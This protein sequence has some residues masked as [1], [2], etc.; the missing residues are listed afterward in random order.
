[1]PDPL[2]FDRSLFPDKRSAFRTVPHDRIVGDLMAAGFPFEVRD[3]GEEAARRAAEAALEHLLGL[4]LAH[5]VAAGG[6]YLF[7]PAEVGRFFVWSGLNGRDGFWEDRYVPTARRL[8]AELQFG[9]GAPPRL[10]RPSELAPRRFHVRLERTF[11]LS[12][13]ATGSRA[14][15][16]MPLPVQDD[17]LDGLDVE[18]IAPDGAKTTRAPGYCAVGLVVD[19]PGPVSITLDA[20]FTARPGRAQAAPLDPADRLL[21]T[22]PKES[23]ISVTDRIRRLSHDITRDGIT[24]D[25]TG[26]WAKIRLIYG[27]L[28]DNFYVADVPYYDVGPDA[29]SE[30]PLDRGTFDCRLGAALFCALC[31]AQDLPARIVSGYQLYAVRAGYHYW[32]EVRDDERGWVPIDFASSHVS[33]AGRDADW[34]DI[35]VGATDYRMK[36]EI[37]PRIFTG[38]GTCRFPP[39]WHMIVRQLAGGTET[40]FEDAVSGGLVYRDRFFVIDPA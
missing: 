22:R 15:L 2:R 10:P 3:G 29:P 35:F 26:S 4:G 19:A 23:L 6:G 24:G 18:V 21:Y 17:A 40:C 33:R 14:S 20:R 7:E 36:L 34:R 25:G 9:R 11:D 32:A 12:G 1:M 28:M 30:W 39:A 38:M 37:L 5:E 31:R 27:F 8:I 16:R 13:L